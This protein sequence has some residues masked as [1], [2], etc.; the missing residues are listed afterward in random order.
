MSLIE[1]KIIL[2]KIAKEYT[3]K[4]KKYSEYHLQKRYKVFKKTVL[5][6]ELFLLKFLIKT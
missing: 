1:K 2:S 6:L 5:K 3:R 4:Y